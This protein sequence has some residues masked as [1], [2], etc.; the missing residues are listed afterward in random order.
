MFAN[1]PSHSFFFFRLLFACEN[2]YKVVIYY[3]FITIQNYIKNVNE[4]KKKLNLKQNF[5]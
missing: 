5:Y 3:L 4:K 2:C 1:K